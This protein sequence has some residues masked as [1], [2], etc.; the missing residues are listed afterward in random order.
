MKVLVVGSEHRMVELKEKLPNTAEVVHQLVPGHDIS[1]YDLIF[2]L[3]LDDN[4]ENLHEYST[5]KKVVIAGM[6][7]MQLA[8]V[9]AMEEEVACTLIGMNT[10]PTFI[11]RDKVEWSLPSGESKEVAEQ[12]ADK[13][14]W[15]FTLVKDRTGMVTPRIILMIINEACYTLQEGTAS[16]ADIDRAMKLGTAYPFGPLEWADKI[17]IDDVYKTLEAI[18]QD[19][20][21]ERYRVCPLLKTMYLESKTFHPV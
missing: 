5:Y 17:G 3:N 7:K 4:P 12:I 8:E 10:L 15:E 21:D 11:S 2:D 18:Y 9:L 1:K 16:I 19:T 14:G 13:L 20:N 6:A